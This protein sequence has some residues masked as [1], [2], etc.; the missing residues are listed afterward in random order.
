MDVEVRERRSK[1][2]KVTGDSKNMD[3]TLDL[4]IRWLM[5]SLKQ[6]TDLK[7]LLKMI[8]QTR[9]TLI[10]QNLK[11]YVRILTHQEKKKLNLFHQLDHLVVV[12]D[13]R[14]L[15]LTNLHKL[16]KFKTIQTNFHLR[17]V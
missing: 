15:L 17:R 12:R 6:K 2:T 3:M 16:S 13:K 11:V 10:L 9:V 4:K 14:I 5:N 1:I 7:I 8:M